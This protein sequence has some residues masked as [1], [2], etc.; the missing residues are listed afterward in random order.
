MLLWTLIKIV[1]FLGIVVAGTYGVTALMESEDGIRF[2]F[3]GVERTL[4]PLDSVLA[5][6]M[7]MVAGWLLFKL[8]G[9]GCGFRSVRIW[10]YNRHQ[11]LL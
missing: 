10:R 11:S 2:T 5:L 3:A 1:I 7:L 4:G 8:V 9:A 6:L